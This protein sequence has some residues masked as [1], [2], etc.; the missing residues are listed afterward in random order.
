MNGLGNQ[1]DVN[2]TTV[3]SIFLGLKIDEANNMR[4]EE[5]HTNF[6]KLVKHENQNNNIVVSPL[7]ILSLGPFYVLGY[8][9]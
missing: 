7:M 4:T 9:Q 5:F 6:R 2:M 3:K 1:I 8:I